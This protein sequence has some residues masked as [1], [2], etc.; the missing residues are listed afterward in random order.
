MKMLMKSIIKNLAKIYCFFALLFLCNSPIY[1]QTPPTSMQQTLKVL[2][3]QGKP[4]ANTEIQFYE[5]QTKEK[6]TI[7]T[8]AAGIATYTFT[9]GHFW[10]FDILEIKDYYE[11]QLEIREGATGN[12]SRTLTYDY[13][14][15]LRVSK[16]AVNRAILKLE[17]ITQN[18]RG[19]EKPTDTESIVTLDI[20]KANKQPLTNFSVHLTCYAL[21]K[22]FIAQT[23]EL[24]KAY[25]KVPN[26]NEY[27]IDIDGIDNYDYVD[28]PNVKGYR[29][30]TYFTYEPTTV[31]EVIKNDTI[32]QNITSADKATSARVISTLTV[33]GG[34]N[35]NPVNNIVYLQAIKAKKV[36]VGQTDN[37]GKV[38][39]LLPKGDSY[40]INFRFQK[41]VDIFNLTRRRGI[42]YSTKTLHYTPQ[43]RLQYPEKFIP[44]PDNLYLREFQIFF[45]KQYPKPKVGD[46]L[47]T[48]AKF[49][50]K[51]NANSTQAILELGFSA[52][53]TDDKN[54]LGEGNLNLAFVVDKSGSMGGDRIENLKIALTAFVEKLRE[55]D[56]VSLTAFD[57]AGKVLISN[58]KIAKNKQVLLDKIHFLE[59]DN[60]TNIWSGL[61]LGYKELQKNYKKGRVNR[62]IL[63]SDGYGGDNP[64]ETIAK[65]KTF[66]DKGLELSAVGVGEDYNIALMQ[67]LASQGGGLIGLTSNSADIQKIFLDEL[68]SLIT[69]IAEDVKVEVLYNKNLLFAQ[70]L[71]FPL[72]EKRDGKLVLKL[73]KIYAG[74][75]DQLG[76]LK[77]TL[78][79]PTQAI[80]SEPIIIIT[81]YYDL[82]TKQNITKETQVKLLWSAV[83]G[84]LEYVVE[85]ED[86]KLYGIAVMNWSL[87]VMAEAFAAKDSKKALA[88]LQQ[89]AIEM[90]K[91]FPSS[92]DEDINKLLTEIETYTVNL[93]TFVFNAQQK[94]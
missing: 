72:E 80:E 25:F 45:T 53:P 77:F 66:N 40:M 31:N 47:L 20:S 35:G 16:P 23:N 7:R 54:V 83:T 70:I 26:N 4:L 89:T 90:K 22:T 49:Y 81:K 61:E 46:G 5:T 28:V 78:I 84:E 93:E 3:N 52:E 34:E 75:S 38:K 48:H 64:V 29:A 85:K 44:T 55:N 33:K 91:L 69:P 15:Y 62:L 11:W 14:N 58:Q 59:A 18:F 92:T 36:Y 63:L 21:N 39:F 94:K 88:T 50:G 43:E 19:N 30:N 65:S 51:I 56:I 10:Q 73:K 1:A 24:G 87:K 82:R 67:K 76:L 12:A 86:K 37:E 6:F 8:N 42:G 57:D 9:K 60:G 71:G 74:L 68:S 27:Q 32:R 17:K 41:N 13:Q 2:D 79:N